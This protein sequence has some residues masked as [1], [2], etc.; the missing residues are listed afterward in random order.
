MRS[1]CP[2]FLSF[3]P[4]L[5]QAVWGGTQLT[6]LLGK[7]LESGS[8]CAE[9]WELFDRT[10][11]ACVVDSGLL[12]GLPI[13]RLLSE[14]ST[15]IFGKAQ[16]VTPFPLLAKFLD[17]EQPTSIQVHPT[18]STIAEFNEQDS[19]K[20]E[21]WYVIAVTEQAKVHA[22]LKAGIDL[23]SFQKKLEQQQTE[24]ILDC[25]NEYI[26]KPGDCILIPAGVVHTM[27]GGLVVAEIQ[28]SSELTYRVH[29]WGR[30]RDSSR[31]LQRQQAKALHAMQSIWELGEGAQARI[32]PACESS[33]CQQGYRQR[34][35]D[36][37]FEMSVLHFNRN[38][39]SPFPL[40]TEDS[41]Q[42]L[43]VLEGAGQ[44][45]TAEQTRLVTAGQ[46][47]LVPAATGDY[48]CEVTGAEDSNL[49]LL[50]VDFGKSL[51]KS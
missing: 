17:V 34:I 29:D 40:K 5:R 6:D 18:A 49:R 35:V 48:T 2:H 28:Q 37:A 1:N 51:I 21:A 41:P 4:Y 7:Q 46:T 25:M 45:K 11:H 9:S 8:L 3:T 33:E 38:E 26:P 32:D 30:G 24:A 22:G 47:L 31:S 50:V 20:T 13:Q 23:A 19:P 36:A 39:A 42:I 15:E 14:Y 43:M 16:Q 10:S 44:L 12:K 27:G